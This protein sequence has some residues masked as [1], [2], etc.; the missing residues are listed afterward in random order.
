[1]NPTAE[2]IRRQLD[3]LL[4]SGGFAQ[5]DRLS[6]FLRY[7]VERTLSGESDQL[8]E[9]VIGVDVF[10]RGQE[11]DPRVDSIV[12]V[13]AGRLRGKIEAYYGGDGRHDAVII[14]LPRGRYVPEFERRP[15]EAPAPVSPGSPS[16]APAARWPG[17][18]LA[19]AGAL[20][21]AGLLGVGRAVF[22]TPGAPA[23]PALR[24]AV[25]PFATYSTDPADRLL[26]AQVT[27]GVAAGIARIGALAVVSR[28]S[29]LG[30]ATAGRSL[31]D[32][33]RALD[34]DI[35]LEASLLKDGDAVRVEARLV[36]AAR[37]RKFWVGEF[38][39]SASNLRGQQSR[40]ASAATA[41]AIKKR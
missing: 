15:D 29:T 23:S 3:R 30:A 25:L 16:A 41:A 26:A 39:G 34:A 9:Y 24:I 4:A 38:T 37:D 32:V 21:V 10:D 19:V 31:T 5:A 12:R 36:D 22:W 28:T 6:R 35:V 1:M 20:L 13:E 33:A 40:V 7:V 27:D 8:K 14:R 18:R 11:Y 17:W 2:E